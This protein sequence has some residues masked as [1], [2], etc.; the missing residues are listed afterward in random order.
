MPETKRSI[1]IELNDILNPSACFNNRS[2]L[3]KSFQTNNIISLLPH[4]LFLNYLH[5]ITLLPLLLLHHLL[6]H[7]LRDYIVH[8]YTLFTTTV[9]LRLF[10]LV[11][12]HVHVIRR[13]KSFLT[14]CLDLTSHIQ[15]NFIWTDSKMLLSLKFLNRALIWKKESKDVCNVIMHHN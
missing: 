14:F 8:Y 5:L 4:I 10:F 2:K 11:S 1:N 13:K 9:F 3:C 12:F 6:L 15:T 7:L